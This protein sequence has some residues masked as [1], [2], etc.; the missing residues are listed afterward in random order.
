MYYAIEWE[1]NRWMIAWLRTLKVIYLIELIMKLSCNDI[2]LWR[3]VGGFYRISCFFFFKW[4]YIRRLVKWLYK[5]LCNFFFSDVV[6]FKLCNAHPVKISWSRHCRE[7]YRIWLSHLDNVSR[8][9]KTNSRWLL[10]LN[11]KL[12]RFSGYFMNL[13]FNSSILVKHTLVFHWYS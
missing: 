8:S 11:M 13:K 6:I 3:I 4:C 2:K 10:H 7:G 9:L 5:T 1:I 12:V